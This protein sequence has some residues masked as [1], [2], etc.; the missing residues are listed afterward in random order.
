MIANIPPVKLRKQMKV[1]IKTGKEKI[2][3]FQQ[4]MDKLKIR[5][6][7]I[8][9][10]LS[11]TNVL[12]RL[13]RYSLR[14]SFADANKIIEYPL[15]KKLALKG[16]RSKAYYI[17]LIIKAYIA[18][19]KYYGALKRANSQ[20]LFLWNGFHL[21]DCATKIAAQHLDMRI[22]YF[23]NG[24]LPSTVQVDSQGINYGSSISK[25]PYFYDNIKQS[26]HII[27]KLVARKP[28]KTSVENRTSL[29]DKFIFVPFQIESDTQIVMYSPWIKSMRELANIILTTIKKHKPETQVV[30]REH[31]SDTKDYTRLK[32]ELTQEGAI[33]AN[34]NDMEEI[35]TK[36]E[37]VVTINSSVGL[38]AIMLGKPVIC[39]GQAMYDIPGIVKSAKNEQQLNS[40]L[41]QEIF[42]IQHTRA[43]KLIWY[44]ENEFLVSGGWR[45]V[46]PGHWDKMHTRLEVL[47]DD[48]TA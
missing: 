44:L 6:Q 37:L 33:F 45:K 7:Y 21:N 46:E 27:K 22:I 10:K 47:L 25:D 11:N 48:Y 30:F 8:D 43:Q 2:K 19:S 38:E 41:S 1:A 14:L 35:I 34:A 3:Y 16:I 29:P 18:S 13:I 24:P 9:K 31:P 17:F 26:K 20:V 4:M 32:D 39:L 28:A 12:P 40:I 42:H 15:N 23:E 5:H 36:A